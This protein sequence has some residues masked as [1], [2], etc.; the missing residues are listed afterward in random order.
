M[1]ELFEAA[2]SPLASSGKPFSKCGK[3]KRYLKYINLK[4]QRLHCINCNE[5]YSLPQNGTIK[6][7]LELAC[8]LDGFQLV[9]FSQGSEGKQYALCPY[10][11][12]NPPFDNIKKI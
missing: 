3:C 7:Y 6:L 4:P 1:D 12:N 10:C 9:L 5:T 2:F 8:P 11:Y